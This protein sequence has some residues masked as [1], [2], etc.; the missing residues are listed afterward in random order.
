MEGLQLLD[1]RRP[2]THP[3]QGQAEQLTDRRRTRRR[4]RQRAKETQGVLVPVTLVR[5]GRLGE[6]VLE[7]R[8]TA[9]SDGGPQLGAR[10]AGDLPAGL[11][12]GATAGAL[13]AR[14]R[15]GAA[16][17]GAL[18]G[19]RGDAVSPL[20][21]SLPAA[22]H[23]PS[24]WLVVLPHPDLGLPLRRVVLDRVV[25]AGAGPGDRPAPGVGGRA[26]G[27]LADDPCTA[28]GHA[29]PGPRPVEM[30]GRPAGGLSA[31]AATGRRP[32]PCRRSAA[33]PG[34]ALPPGGSRCA[35]TGL[36]GA[37]GP[38]TA[39]LLA[40]ARWPVPVRAEWSVPTRYALRLSRRGASDE[41]SGTPA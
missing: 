21:A 37:G 33:G 18:T 15:P 14:W 41:V 24:G 5:P 9:G 20:R 28:T 13:P 10:L 27:R 32:I 31:P 1:G 22:G 36:V 4:R 25:L 23:V 16:A 12:R 26:G 35:G 30:L 7:A 40:P 34:R 2:A 11:P 17:T 39:A 38:A 6:P 3:V 19:P 8:G 29:A